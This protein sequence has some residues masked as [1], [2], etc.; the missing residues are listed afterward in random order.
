[1]EVNTSRSYHNINTL[2]GNSSASSFVVLIIIRCLALSIH[3]GTLARSIEYVYQAIVDL[4]SEGC[5][6]EDPFLYGLG[7]HC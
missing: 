7:F 3:P 2:W 6:L 4:V 1:V 5:S